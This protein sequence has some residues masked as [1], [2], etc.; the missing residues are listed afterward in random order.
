[1]PNG[2][3]EVQGVTGEE[4][5]RLPSWQKNSVRIFGRLFHRMIAVVS[6]SRFA[7]LGAVGPGEH[8]QQQSELTL[9]L[10][11]RPWGCRDALTVAAKL[12]V[13]LFCQIWPPVRIR[14]MV[15]E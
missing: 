2:L 9:P 6:E 8:G 11:F 1:V 7:S 10:T 12:L 13:S 15:V 14:W 4:L 5:R 3:P